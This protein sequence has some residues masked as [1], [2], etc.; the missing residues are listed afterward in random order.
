MPRFFWSAPPYVTVASWLGWHLASG[1]RSIAKEGDYLAHR[2]STSSQTERSAWLLRLIVSCGLVAGQV[3]LVIELK[4]AG[5]RNG[6]LLAAVLAGLARYRGPFALMSLDSRLVA[7]LAERAPEIVRGI[8]A[9]RTID[10]S[11]G[12]LPF[13]ERL[14]QLSAGKVAF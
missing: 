8:V 4:S 13:G 10:R 5:R 14:D 12:T 9:D 11:W 2:A 3:L 1:I 7:G 6:E